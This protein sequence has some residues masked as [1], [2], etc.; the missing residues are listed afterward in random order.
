M[1]ANNENRCKL[2]R[3]LVFW[4]QNLANFGSLAVLLL[5]PSRDPGSEDTAR[6]VIGQRI[7]RFRIYLEAE[8][9]SMPDFALPRAEETICAALDTLQQVSPPSLETLFI[10]KWILSQTF[11]DSDLKTLIGDACFALTERLSGLW[12]D[13]M[14]CPG[15]SDSQ[16]V[17]HFL[18]WKGS[19]STNKDGIHGVKLEGECPVRASRCTGFSPL[20][21]GMCTHCTA[22]RRHLQ[23]EKSAYKTEPPGL[24][25]ALATLAPGFRSV[26]DRWRNSP[27]SSASSST[28]PSG[29]P[30]S[31]AT[32]ATPS[33]SSES[34][35]HLDSLGTD[36]RSLRGII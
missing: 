2:L 24:K 3:V 20:Q 25:F 10:A 33:T 8:L 21:K 5:L 9:Q 16:L 12:S 30:P 4:T 29:A 27:S 6:C 15:I 32:P 17:D 36:T 7:E 31:P 26:F 14:L 1:L 11:Q 23:K 22:L 13:K 19:V 28:V 34:S 35:D 18:Y